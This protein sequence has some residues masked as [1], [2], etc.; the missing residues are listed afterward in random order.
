MKL[1]KSFKILLLI[2]V[3]FTSFFISG[4]GGG[5]DSSSEHQKGT[6]WTIMVYADGD[7][8]LEDMLLMDIE[9]MKRGF[10]NSQGQNLIVLADRYDG[11]YSIGFGQRFTDTRLFEISEDKAK[12][13]SGG[14]QFPEITTT[15]YYE[16][17]MGDAETLKKFI[18]FCKANYTAKNYA[19]VLWNHG[20]GP[21]KA[22]GIG[23]Y[24]SAV[25]SPVKAICSDDT[26]DDILYTAEIT[27]VLTEEESVDLLGFDAC[28]MGSVEVAYQY[29]PG[30]GDFGA[31]VM[32][33]SPANEW[34]YG[35][36]YERI[37]KRLRGGGGNNGES[38]HLTG[39]LE[40]YYDPAS[41]TA[42][43]LG[44]V[45]V[46][47]Q[48]DSTSSQTDQTM[49]CYDLS[50][51]GA[52]KTAVDALA[53]QLV[54][55][56]GKEDFEGI[57][58]INLDAVAMHYFNESD[59]DE[60]YAWP[61]FDLYDLCKKT[62]NDIDDDFNQTVEDNAYAVM[63]AVGDMVKYSF[64]G[65][66]FSGFEEKKNGISI[67]FP[68]GDK[69]YTNPDNITDIYW[70]FQWWYNSIDTNTDYAAGYYYGKLAWCIDVV[71]ESNNT[72]E[73]WFEMLDSWFDTSNGGDGGLNGY[74]W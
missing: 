10:V 20:N 26:D 70:A 24:V 67:F 38:S 72:V 60:W 50:K 25:E 46:E 28:I 8:N 65:S 68:D 19:L 2:A 35:W 29:R 54:T 14:S 21:R 57:R 48:Y 34:G 15:S 27:D 33:A 55:E 58:G 66:D 73:N 71:I 4:C 42:L 16:G 23:D 32:V 61:L 37:M 74:Q 17:N 13:I 36:D 59:A 64:A 22:K 53:V 49:S 47:E 45:I 7:N 3:S 41:M 52:V 56:G 31:D 5:D 62:D 40:A 9:E 1:Y 43:Q 69:S 6:D 18:R 39:G 12:R 63:T 51:V 44:E 30:T 11:Y